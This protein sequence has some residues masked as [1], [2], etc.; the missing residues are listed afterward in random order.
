MATE[1]QSASTSQICPACGVSIDTTNAEPL[2]TIDCPN[3]GEKVRAE[4]MFD[5]FVIVETVGVGGMGTVYKA[6]DVSLDRFVALK[7][8]RKDVESGLDA[9]AELRQE[10]RAAAAVNHPNI[11]QVF[12]SG[13]A[14]GQFY[15]VM[16]LVEHGSLDDLIE[17]Q[18]RVGEEQVLEIGIQAAKGLRAAHAKG[19]VHR[20]VK[21]ANILFADEHLAKIG[22]FGLAGA[23]AE[24]RGEIW[25]TPFYVA[26]ERL[27]H[28]PEDLRSDIYS[29]GATLFHAIAGRAP[30]EGETNSATELFALKREPL[31]LSVVAPEISADTARA[32]QRMIAPEPAQRFSSYDDLV[33][34]LERA[35]KKLTGRDM[36]DIAT[37][38][39]KT[40]R[41]IAAAAAV[42]LIAAIG[43]FVYVRKTEQQIAVSSTAIPVAELE[44]Q[45]ADARHQLLLNHYNVAG[46]AFARIANEARGR[47]PLHDWARMQQALAAMIARDAAQTREALQAIENAG[48]KNFSKEDV[49]L[50]NS[51]IANARKLLS[52]AA[53]SPNQASPVPPDLFGL[54]ASALKDVNQLEINGASQLLDQFI[55]A[56]P[57][58]K[59]AWISEFRPLAQKY[60]DDCRLYLDWKTHADALPPD[61]KQLKVR[62]SAIADAV[63]GKQRPTAADSPVEAA[64]PMP[65]RQLSQQEQKDAPQKKSQWLAAWKKR[66]IDDLNRKQFSG[67]FTDT[68]G[69]QYTGI[70]AADDQS[71]SLKLPYGIARVAWNKVRPQTLLTVSASFIRQNAADTADRQWL[72]AVY[73][74]AT[75][76]PETARQLAEAAAQGNPDYREQIPF[77]GL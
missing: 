54:L 16:E 11:V 65:A 46:S 26:P 73:A 21:P 74:S 39:R 58:G 76:Q 36:I 25:G 19:L 75:N 56:Q 1:Q 63:T 55:K 68:S 2:Q 13:T 69:A 71:L 64:P 50:A 72:C 52:P 61:K 43:I 10:A 5:N 3:C 22:D 47:Q 29:L 51:F 57:S 30:I 27:N 15:L 7:L 6:R 35:Y 28:Q 12:S 67:E 41:I 9:T 23:A 66:L 32:L 49:D 70:A 37:A 38:K 33:A 34:E 8:L 48:T 17:Q 14:H 31:L 20:D 44:K 4:R 18:K 45:A 59:F 42:L 62:N 24:A 40:R 60:L 53:I 77:L